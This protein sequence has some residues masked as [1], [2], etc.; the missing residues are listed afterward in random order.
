MG[1]PADDMPDQPALREDNAE[2][3]TEEAEQACQAADSIES[4][5]AR[6]LCSPEVEVRNHAFETIWPKL[7]A[8]LW[9]AG[10]AL[11]HARGGTPDDVRDALNETALRVL[12]KV[13]DGAYQRLEHGCFRA[14]CWT[15][16]K[17]C[18]LGDAR[19]HLRFR[20]YA[21]RMREQYDGTSNDEMSTNRALIAEL[22]ATLPDAQREVITL[23][24]QGYSDEEIGQRLG[25]TAD[26]V[27]Q[28]HSRGVRS[29]RSTLE[30]QRHDM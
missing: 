28:R 23:R 25:I 13:G 18:L 29:I 15:I 14:W 27:R 17:H 6:E 8:Y 22:V 20:R 30:G 11:S 2:F 26:N 3:L 1:K 16:L 19:S 10:L 5:V 21:E 9:L 7:E 12:M 4:I 24:Y